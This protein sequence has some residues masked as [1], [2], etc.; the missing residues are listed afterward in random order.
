MERPADKMKKKKFR[1]V[2]SEGGGENV[3]KKEIGHFS[4]R[5][6]EIKAT[7]GRDEYLNGP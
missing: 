2:N 5:G 6:S 3:L 1:D 7:E 4:R